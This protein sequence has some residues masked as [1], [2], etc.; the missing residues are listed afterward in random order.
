MHSRNTHFAGFENIL[1]ILD[2]PFNLSDRTYDTAMILVNPTLKLQGIAEDDRC[3][4][5]IP[6][7]VRTESVC[8]A[9]GATMHW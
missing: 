8:S 1:M 4:T 3:S 7:P 9:A 5:S 2:V 6:N